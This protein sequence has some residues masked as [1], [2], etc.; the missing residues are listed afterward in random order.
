MRLQGIEPDQQ[1]I[2]RAA[3]QQQQVQQ[4]LK[5]NNQ[6]HGD[7]T[8]QLFDGACQLIEASRGKSP[9]EI[10]TL[11]QGIFTIEMSKAGTPAYGL[12]RAIVIL[13]Q[14]GYKNHPKFA[15]VDQMTTNLAK[16]HFATMTPAD[17]K[18]EGNEEKYVK[19]VVA[20]VYEKN[21][22]KVPGV[23]GFLGRFMDKL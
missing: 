21:G 15:N 16:A 12:S 19:G 3:D 17:Q 6:A 8:K 5:A 7:A 11:A 23:G 14:P 9:Q 1:M 20:E 18:L 22:L 13:K 2:Q 10:V 4:Q